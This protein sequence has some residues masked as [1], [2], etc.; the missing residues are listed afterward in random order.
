MLTDSLLSPLL[1]CC[2]PQDQLNSLLAE[3]DE[4]KQMLSEDDQTI[5][6]LRQAVARWEHG[7]QASAREV[8]QKIKEEQDSRELSRQLSH[9]QQTMKLREKQLADLREELLR[10]QQQ[11]RESS[12][13]SSPTA[14]S[15]RQ[16]AEQDRSDAEIR[17]AQHKIAALER[18]VNEQRHRSDLL[19]QR[20]DQLSSSQH[21]RAGEK[22][23]DKAAE[24]KQLTDKIAQLE[25]SQRTLQPLAST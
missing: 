2:C 13:A 5:S 11:Q 6:T 1:R 23:A 14:A 24:R 16:A 8:Q 9:V 20:N 22:D 25:H 19:Q 3:I 4:Q 15:G 17:A 10:V 18:E 21:Q 12:A 7:D